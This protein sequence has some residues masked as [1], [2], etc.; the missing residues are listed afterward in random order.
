MYYIEY[1]FLTSGEQRKMI[2]K[3]IDTKLILNTGDFQRGME[4]RGYTEFKGRC[5]VYKIVIESNLNRSRQGKL[6]L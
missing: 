5:I 1:D 4:I 3:P 6:G 2:I